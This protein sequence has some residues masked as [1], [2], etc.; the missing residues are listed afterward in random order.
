MR[1]PRNASP[2]P[3]TAAIMEIA[4]A[5]LAAAFGTR[6]FLAVPA[7]AQK[8][9]QNERRNVILFVMDGLRY[10]S[11]NPID[12]PNLYFIQQHGIDFQNSHALYPTVTTVNASALATGH[13]VGDT[14]DYANTIWIGPGCH[15]SL[16]N[17]S[18]GQVT[19]GLEDD[20][21]LSE[22]YRCGGYMQHKTL[23]ALARE[24]G[25]QTAVIGKAGP[26]GIQVIDQL[27]SAQGEIETP[28]SDLV[29]HKTNGFDPD[30]GVPLRRGFFYKLE[31]KNIPTKP[32][33]VPKLPNLEEQKAQQGY[34]TDVAKAWLQD[35]GKSG[36]RSGQPFVLVFWSRDPDAT[37]HN[38][39][40]SLYKF[41]PGINGPTSKAALRIADTSV[42]EIRKALKDGGLADTTD[43]I[44]VADH[45]FSTISKHNVDANVNREDTAHTGT[46]EAA[47]GS[48]AAKFLYE[49]PEKP[50]KI[51]APK[52]YLPPGFLAVDVA[53]KLGK[54]LY[55]PASRSKTKQQHREVVVPTHL[56]DGKQMV[57][58]LDE[59]DKKE[60]RFD[61]DQEEFPQG[62]S[63]LIGGKGAV[64]DESS[65]DLIVIASGGSDLI[66][67]PDAKKNGG[68]VRSVCEFLGT[69]N[70]VDGLF[71][72]S[73]AF[74]C[75][76]ALPL[77]AIG[78]KGDA[79][80]ENPTDDHPVVLP[81]PA[82]VVNFKSFTR[83]PHDN[84]DK[85]DDLQRRVEIADTDL[86]DGQG[87]HGS[88]SRADTRNFMAAIGP[89][90]RSGY[91]DYCPVSNADIAPTIA[92][93]LHL[94]WEVEPTGREIAEARSSSNKPDPSCEKAWESTPLASST[95]TLNGKVTLLEGESYQGH[96]YYDQAC[97]VQDGEKSKGCRPKEG[98]GAIPG[99]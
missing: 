54:R 42:G 90:F 2:D 57:H 31:A 43:I 82:I 46:V 98:A 85:S 18:S 94:R 48:Y 40:D 66:Y 60:S 25:I 91:R 93:L 81:H 29:D 10:G 22:I 78:M 30:D 15:L 6:A 63:W 49:D 77:A 58:H 8:E 35:F 41:D 17:P 52:G 92:G 38:Q 12:S 84:Q 47:H 7:V 73:P 97:V 74:D 16:E 62:G 89:D 4:R 86:L 53:H 64:G 1:T 45:G 36:T 5:C 99:Q 3:V 59:D 71:V 20:L 50:G 11:V 65:S 80:L 61:D 56:V 95:R 28:G 33:E 72:D 24:R 27:K 37:Q 34:F 79:W 88:F 39:E 23:L 21:N 96:D 19:V 68:L 76:G 44:V 87:Q 51:V 83:P 75:P 67:V 69:W 9:Q 14:G 26:V 13:K 55:D 32:P 70:Y